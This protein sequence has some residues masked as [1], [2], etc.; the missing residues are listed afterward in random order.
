MD[1]LA[2]WLAGRTLYQFIL[3][4][5]KM[6]VEPVECHANSFGLDWLGKMHKANQELT[7]L[8]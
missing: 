6:H 1:E 2:L 7:P 4:S 3:H 8:H 5:Q